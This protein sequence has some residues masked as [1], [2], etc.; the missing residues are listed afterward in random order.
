MMHKRFLVVTAIFSVSLSGCST[1]ATIFGKGDPPP[2]TE[3]L[4]DDI[5]VLNPTT[6]YEWAVQAYEAGLYKEAQERFEDLERDKSSTTLFYLI[7]FYLGQIYYRLGD[8]PQSIQR[9]ESYLS[10]VPQSERNQE[11]RMTL[12]SAY[13]STRNWSKASVLAAETQNMSLYTGNQVLLRLLWAESLMHQGEMIGAE[14]TLRIAQTTLAQIPEDSQIG[15]G[16]V[17][18]EERLGERALWLETR[19][20]SARCTKISVPARPQPSR[21][22]RVL[23]EWYSRKA[24]CAV[25]VIE[26]ALPVFGRL[27]PRWNAALL[28]TLVETLEEVDLAPSL[29]VQERRIEKLSVAKEGAV[30]PYRKHFYS[31]LNRFRDLFENVPGGPERNFAQ[32]RLTAKVEEILQKIAVES[33]KADRS[34]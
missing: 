2:R 30:E 26:A 24:Q 23:T 32:E 25:R 31:L 8:Y 33:S 29:L 21:I 5:V 16:P 13:V 22:K 20:A 15:Q 19:I 17:G 1:V 11:T 14:R 4:G 34:L 28:Q 18:L 10:R 7:P 27:G 9:L 6:A 3:T 12:L